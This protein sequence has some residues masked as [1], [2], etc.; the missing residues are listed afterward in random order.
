MPTDDD[1]PLDGLR[2]RI[3]E[4][5]EAAE[6]V[7]ADAAA[8]REREAAGEPAGGGFSTTEEHG[9]RTGEVQ[10]LVALLET[11]RDLIPAEL[12]DQFRELLRQM[13]LLVRALIDWWVERI[14]GAGGAASRPAPGPGLEDIPLA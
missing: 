10:A 8:A 14:E 1:D 6:R 7:A 3:R 12:K 9:R 13:L 2:E 4:T 11:L 5:R